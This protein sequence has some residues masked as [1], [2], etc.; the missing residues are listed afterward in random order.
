M[1]PGIQTL[2]TDASRRSIGS[3]RDSGWLLVQILRHLGLAARFVS[4]YL[5][6][7]TADEKSLDGPSGP[8]QRLHRPARLGRGVRA[9]RRLD[10]ARPDLGPV[11][12]RGSHPAR[13]HA[14]S[15]ERR[16]GHRRRPTSARSSST[17]D[18]DVRARARGPAR[19]Q[20]VHR[21]RSG[22]RSTRSAARVDRE[23]PALRRAPH[24]G[25]RADVR[26]DRRHGGRRVEHGGARRAQARARRR[27]RS[28]RLQDRV[29]A[30]RRSCTTGRASG[31][32]ASRCR[33][34]RSAATGAA[35]AQPLWQRRRARRRRERATTASAPTTRA[36]RAAL[37]ERLGVDAQ[38]RHPRPT[39][40]VVHYLWREAS[41]AD[42][43][44]P[45]AIRRWTLAR[46]ARRLRAGAR[47]RARPSRR[48]RAAA[49]WDWAVGGWHSGP[50]TSRAAR[51]S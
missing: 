18:N 45:V 4:G 39:R 37:A 38:R 29:R 5:V 12:R 42:R 13:L 16:A 22:R 7:L 46:R 50:G 2:R 47:A 20:A 35:T 24:D 40:T 32:P 11:R 23:L 26:V 51:C 34:G 41:A 19:H 9:G 44:D 48:L 3:C 33:A 36:L 14:R 30:R 17:I 6:Q 15:G 31:I 21:R 8:E 28:Q 1:D 43:R 10:R 25:R 27:S 49:R